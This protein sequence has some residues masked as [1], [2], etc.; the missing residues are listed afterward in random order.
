[1]EIV[2]PTTHGKVRGREAAGPGG[3]AAFL[4]IPYA[5]PPFGPRRLR[6]PQSPEPWDGERNAFDYGPTAPKP[7][8]PPALATLLPDP[9]VPGEECLNLNV[10]T[11]APGRDSALPVMVWIHGGAFRNG[12]TAVPVYDGTAF[13]RD[14]VVCVTANYRLGAE[15]FLL[16]PDGTAN[17]GLLDQIAALRWVREN[18]AAFGGDPDN[19]TL[20]GESAGAMSAT[21]LM[22]VPSAAG[23]FRRVIA[24]SGAGHHALPPDIAR[25]ITARVAAHAGVPATAEVLRETAPQRLVAAVSAV[26]AEF[27]T[28]HGREEW[29]EAAGGGL[30][31][32]PVVDG[33]VLPARPVDAFAAGAGREYGLLTGTNAEEFRLY[34][35]PS[36]LADAIPEEALP[37]LLAGHGPEPHRAL[38]AYRAALPDASPGDLLAAVLT[39]FTFRIPAVRVA[40]ARAAHGAATYVYTFDWR[41]P[42]FDGRL[43]ACHAL[44]IGFVF[45]NLASGLLGG[46]DAPQRLADEMHAAWVAFAH[47]GDP[48]PTWPAYGADRAV[49]R[50]AA[51]PTEVVHDPAAAERRLWDGLR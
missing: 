6:P 46:G 8:Y 48:G 27:A 31:L 36:G 44:E 38:A 21:T 42:A 7:G 19:V 41:S 1:M 10:W 14:G 16:L 35:V 49:L 32:M 50:F 22:T 37:T 47:H 28:G 43:G 25:R 24:Q 18:I 45:D 33:E 5:A 26:Q 34:L 30:P 13:A 23:L 2:V 40:E 4:G 39:D 29:G 15:G 12:S 11:P 3:V 20:F 51:D 9:V 17:L